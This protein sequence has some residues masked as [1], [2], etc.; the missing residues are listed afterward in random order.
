MKSISVEE[1][2]GEE[3]YPKNDI[4][5]NNL[6]YFFFFIFKYNSTDNM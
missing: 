6:I 2:K 3:G 5:E 4:I 1:D